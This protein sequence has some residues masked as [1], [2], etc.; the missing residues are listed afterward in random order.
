MT[1][2]S[3]S[4]LLCEAASEGWRACL[5]LELA[6][7]G[8]RSTIVSRAH[9]GPLVVQRPF[10]PEPD[11]TCHVLLLHPPG[12]MVAG[13]TL[14][15][16]CRVREGARALLTTPAATKLYRARHRALRATQRV[17]VHVEEN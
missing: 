1:S 14:E 9:E 11:G 3:I 2:S 6:R 5:R 8:S 17:S 4:T 13:D 15:L 7:S 16:S 12:G 10:H